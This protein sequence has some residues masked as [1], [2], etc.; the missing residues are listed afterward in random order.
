MTALL[1]L[2]LAGQDAAAAA[3]GPVEVEIGVAGTAEVPAQGYRVSG[4]FFA[5]G[6]SPEE[7]GAQVASAKTAAVAAIRP[8][9]PI[10]QPVCAPDPYK[11]G[12]VGNE[13]VG[14]PD[15]DTQD[16][17][18][19]VVPQ[20]ETYQAVFRDRQSAERAA[21]ALRQAGARNIQGP[22]GVLFDC[23]AA[24]RAAQADALTRGR[25]DAE[26]YAQQLGLRVLGVR[27]IVQSSGDNP[28]ESLQLAM[29]T[30][31]VPAPANK[32]RFVVPVKVTYLLDR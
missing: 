20:F 11:L 26:A 8:L 6:V 1:A 23:A 24:R 5:P 25:P 15:P 18:E 12:F 4:Y 28:L 3:P 32:V 29:T 2:L 13:A 9:G 31:A 17:D 27:R 14:G 19:P 10:D 21:A 16:A 22:S 7:A 30:Q